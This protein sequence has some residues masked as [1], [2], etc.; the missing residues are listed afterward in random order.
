MGWWPGACPGTLNG[1]PV[2]GCMGFEE[3]GGGPAILAT[4]GVYI[5]IPGVLCRPPVGGCMGAAEEVAME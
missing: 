1:C 4:L 5:G 3:G 2:D